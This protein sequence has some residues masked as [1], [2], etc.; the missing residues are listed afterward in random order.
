MAVV[1]PEKRTHDYHAQADVL[2]GELRLPL[3][4]PIKSQA[5]AKLSENG[6]YIAQHELDYRLESVMSFR[7]AHT[8]VAGNPGVKKGHGWTT[9]ASS[10]VEGLNILNV[11][12]AD[13]VVGQVSL[14]Y[15][16]VGYVPTIT[17]L[18]TRF[19]NLKIAGH[20]VHVHLNLDIL[21]PRPKVPAPDAETAYTRDRSFLDRARGQYGEALT[22]PILV[23]DAPPRLFKDGSEDVLQ[24]DL[25][26]RYSNSPP[27]R[28][29]GNDTESVRCSLVSGIK[30]EFPGKR[31]GHLIE[32]P[33]FGTMI[34]GELCI[35]NSVFDG[36]TPKKTLVQLTMIELRM[37]CIADGD[38]SVSSTIANGMTKP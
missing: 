33:D 14:D 37:G 35:E 12:T 6:G 27:A 29:D 38:T 26:G 23:K 13:L 9:L 24:K 11:I 17:F 3:K 19:E 32:I 8:H 34:L 15:P 20:P 21:G 10:V 31:H 4:Q 30:G 36:A 22:H 5:N 18:G 28:S 7:A 2:V 1:P 25:S 16:E